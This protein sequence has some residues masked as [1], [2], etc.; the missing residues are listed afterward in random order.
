MVANGRKN[1]ALLDALT[2]A[3]NPQGGWSYEP[4]KAS[5]LEPTCWALMARGLQPNHN[6]LDDSPHRKFFQSCQHPRGWLVEDASWPVNVA[7]NAVVA[8]TWVNRPDLTTEAQMTNL[9]DRLAA[10]KGVPLPQVP[11]YRQDNTLQGWSWLD[12][13]FSWV[14][15]T[16]WGLLALRKAMR[17]GLV[18]EGPARARIAEAER[19]LVDRSC[20]DGGWNFGNSNVLGQDLFAHVP[21]TAVALLALQGRRDEPIV[22]R[23][24]AF[25]ESNWADEPSTFSLGLSMICLQ[26]HDRPVDAIADR[27]SSIVEQRLERSRSVDRAQQPQNFH[28]LAV[29]LTALSLTADDATFRL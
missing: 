16:A 17:A 28:S 2:K 12:A 18:A 13:T 3:A 1:V 11:S 23:S 29:A 8:F 26:A 6:R 15:P 27:L 4:G 9:V 22:A 7:F 14:E 21:T 5:R 10:E 20:R 24:L 19:L 25:L